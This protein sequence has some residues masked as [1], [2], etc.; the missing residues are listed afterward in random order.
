MRLRHRT[1]PSGPALRAGP[2]GWGCAPNP[3][4][5][6]I[7]QAGRHKGRAARLPTRYSNESPTRRGGICGRDDSFGGRSNA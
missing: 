6:N 2:S 7:H 5:D 3:A 4:K 1:E